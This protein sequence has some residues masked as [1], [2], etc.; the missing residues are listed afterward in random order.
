[1]R[2]DWWWPS[3]PDNVT[4]SRPVREN[5]LLRLTQRFY[6]VLATLLG[7]SRAASACIVYYCAFAKQFLYIDYLFHLFCKYSLLAVESWLLSP[8][9]LLSLRLLDLH[10]IDLFDKLTSIIRC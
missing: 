2:Y 7:L 6:P 3:D 9:L 10:A 4:H 8:S 1:M 5:L